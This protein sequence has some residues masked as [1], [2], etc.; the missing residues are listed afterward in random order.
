MNSLKIQ[1]LFRNP[2]LRFMSSVRLAVPL[3]V[4]MM[5]TVATGTILESLYDA[6]YAKAMIYNSNLFLLLILLLWLNIALATLSRFPLKK[7]HLGF[8]ITHLGLLTLL[9]GSMVTFLWG[10]DGEV[11]IFEG[12]KSNKAL[13]PNI[14]LQLPPGA[15]LEVVEKH[16]FATVTQEF[17]KS[18]NIEDKPALSLYV[19]N[20][21]SKETIWL[22][23]ADRP[24]VQLGPVTFVLKAKEKKAPNKGPSK[25]SLVVKRKL[26]DQ[27]VEKISLPRELPYKVENIT[28]RSIKMFKNAIVKKQGLSEGEGAGASNPALEMQIEKN[29]QK[30]REVIFRQFPDFSINP[31]GIFGYTFVLQ[32]GASAEDSYEGGSGHVIEISV[33]L[34]KPVEDFYVSVKKDGEIL[35]NV[36]LK[37]GQPIETPWM[38]MK[39]FLATYY[40]HAKLETK[41]VRVKAE[42]KKKIP[43]SGIVLKNTATDETY[44]LLAGEEKSILLDSKRYS[45]AYQREPYILPFEI[46]LLKFTKKDYPGTDRPFAFESQVRVGGKEH[47]ISMNEPL[48]THG[49][50]IYQASYVMPIEG[51]AAISVFSVNKD[52]GRWIKY[53]G[54]V[55]LAI[56]IIVFT[57]SKSS[58]FKSSFGERSEI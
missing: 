25:Y 55:I 28:I 54:S 56:G 31:E 9:G 5:I 15:P 36:V 57:L 47:L 16:S 27:V 33:D 32:G 43:P 18:K 52:P 24:V 17:L 4:V 29:G 11:S 19:V 46:E 13:L 40:P 7:R 44:F 30:L 49:Y 41:M 35:Q 20:P 8:A 23:I 45:I 12:E 10:I 50:T 21:F 48:K 38:Q 6:Q 37:Q 51:G 34:E 2:V 3:M 26:D 39:V 1:I 42:P 14:K 22:G 53:L 58:Y